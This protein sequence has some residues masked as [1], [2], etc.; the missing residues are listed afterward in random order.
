M[1]VAGARQQKAVLHGLFRM[2]CA[3]S[4]EP[5]KRYRK[6]SWVVQ[7]IRSVNKHQQPVILWLASEIITLKIA[8]IWVS[9]AQG[10][11]PVSISTTKQPTLQ[12]SAFLVWPVCFTTSGAIQN[13]EPCKDG[14]LIRLPVKRSASKS[15][16]RAGKKLTQRTYYH[17]LS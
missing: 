9:C 6:E 10:C 17:R 2:S 13:T 12:I 5:Q 16:K 4:L 7:R 15:I 1:D 14:L 3:K 8:C 11:S